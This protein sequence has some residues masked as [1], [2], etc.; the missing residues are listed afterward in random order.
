MHEVGHVGFA[1]AVFSDMQVE[2]ELDQCAVQ[3]RE[4]TRHHHEARARDASRGFEVHPQALADR[5]MILGLEL[6]RRRLAPA[7]DLDVRVLVAARRHA[8]VQNIGQTQ[9]QILEFGLQLLE[10]LG[11]PLERHAQGLAG[12]EQRGAILALGLC[13]ADRLRVGIALGAQ[14]V[15]LDLH[16]LAALFD[17]GDTGHVEHEAAARQLRCHS[18]QIAAQQLGIE[19]D[20]SFPLVGAAE[21]DALL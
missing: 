3:A 7:A 6:E 9:L 21:V 17:R 18:G 1:V 10:L 15:R 4:R 2:H 12:R 19:H 13:V 8:C 5:D 20:V 14:P 11:N 16:R